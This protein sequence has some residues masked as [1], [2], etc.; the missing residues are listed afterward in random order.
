MKNR[1]IETHIDFGNVLI[2]KVVQVNQEYINGV[3]QAI[4]QQIQIDYNLQ[5]KNSQI[6][7][8]EP[9]SII[10]RPVIED[11]VIKSKTAMYLM[12]FPNDTTLTSQHPKGYCPR[13]HIH[14]Y[15]ERN[16]LFFIGE[17]TRLLIQSLSPISLGKN[18]EA[19]LKEDFFP[20]TNR[21]RY[22]AILKPGIFLI[23]LALNTSHNFVALGDNVATITLHPQEYEELQK[24][25]NSQEKDSLAFSN[26]QNQT[27]FLQDE[28]GT[29]Q[30]CYPGS[31][32][33]AN[34]P[35]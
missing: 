13:M 34:Y 14:P 10:S 9:T 27:I 3:V 18:T 21:K 30:N 35:D 22:H 17:N 33:E 23:R 29:I 19:I 7:D 4:S 2:Q 6:F 25:N 12:K 24:V 20:E 15:G 26:M 5:D 32:N 16:I 8:G 1:L 11:G 31:I 28:P